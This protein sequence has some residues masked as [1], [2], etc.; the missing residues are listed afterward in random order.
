MVA[1]LDSEGSSIPLARRNHS[2]ALS[3]AQR[4][5][6]RSHWFNRDELLIFGGED[7]REAESAVEFNGDGVVVARD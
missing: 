4:I 3:G 1:D 7:L 2:Q 5:R 6:R